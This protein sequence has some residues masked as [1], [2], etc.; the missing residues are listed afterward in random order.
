M[1]VRVKV[2]GGAFGGRGLAWARSAVGCG[3]GAGGKVSRLSG[4]VGGIGQSASWSVRGVATVTGKRRHLGG[5]CEG[6]GDSGTNRDQPG[7]PGTNRDPPGPPDALP[8]EERGAAAARVPLVR[9]G[10]ADHVAG[11]AA[12]HPGP[13]L[14]PAGVSGAPPVSPPGTPGTPPNHPGD[15]T[16]SPS[17]RKA[18]P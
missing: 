18:S 7:P 5:R 14:R 1:R 6:P 11:R 17:G 10:P 9:R 3:C 2:R 16:C 15:P 12:A 13:G 4:H 8:A